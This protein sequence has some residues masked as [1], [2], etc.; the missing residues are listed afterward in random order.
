MIYVIDSA[1]VP[2]SVGA[3]IQKKSFE[4]TKKV[5]EYW[6]KKWPETDPKLVRNLT[7]GPFRI[8]W[9]WK[10]KSLADAEQFEKTFWQDSGIKAIMAEWNVAEKEVGSLLLMQPTRNYM[11]DVE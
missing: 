8:S 9:V 6:H 10:V 5:I 4:L 2:E 1:T 3:V 7:G 11:A